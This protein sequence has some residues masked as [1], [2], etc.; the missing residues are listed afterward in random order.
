[1]LNRT[2]LLELEPEFSTVH[3]YFVKL[4]ESKGIDFEAV[5]RDA[6]AVYSVLPHNDLI[7]RGDWKLLE[8][9]NSGRLEQ[10]YANCWRL[11]LRI[12]C[13]IAMF[14]ESS[15]SIMAIEAENTTA[16]KNNKEKLK[17]TK[18]APLAPDEKRIVMNKW[19]LDSYD[20]RMLV[21]KMRQLYMTYFL[22]VRALR[23]ERYF[24]TSTV[25]RLVNQYNPL[26][27]GFWAALIFND[28]LFVRG[29][30]V[31]L[32]IF[33]VAVVSSVVGI[34]IYKK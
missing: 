33:S 23:R 8:A 20:Q 14:R 24:S 29:R 22:S 21:K 6:D 10:S 12:S 25:R 32:S 34:L 1:M 27:K 15:F 30:D 28:L 13:S 16:E 9:I 11:I 5:L 19:R 17:E 2:S 3:N 26:S 7:H 4:P 18:V 31:L